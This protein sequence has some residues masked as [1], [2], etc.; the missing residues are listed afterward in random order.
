MRYSTASTAASVKTAT[1]TV[2]RKMCVRPSVPIARRARLR[3]DHARQHQQRQ[4]RRHRERAGRGQAIAKL[5]ARKPAPIRKA[6]KPMAS[7]VDEIGFWR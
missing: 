6:T 7:G 3:G 2:A 1:P 5:A 4:H